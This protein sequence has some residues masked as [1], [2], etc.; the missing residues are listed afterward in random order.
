MKIFNTLKW[1]G[2]A[3]LA[4]PV[5]LIIA[6]IFSTLIKEPRES[7]F[8]PK[9]KKETVYDT[10]KVQVYDTVRVKIYDTVQIQEKP[11]PVITVQTTINDTIEN[12]NE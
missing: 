8:T 3:V 11:K 2:Y 10:I 12:T 5:S 7:I 6:I 4:I 9:Q 1:T